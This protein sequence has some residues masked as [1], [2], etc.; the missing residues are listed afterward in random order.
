MFKC[1][2]KSLVF[3]ELIIRLSCKSA[4]DVKCILYSLQ[5]SFFALSN[6][7]PATIMFPKDLLKIV[8]F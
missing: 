4:S 3:I 7:P 6:Y 1:G 5:L 2:K 8:S